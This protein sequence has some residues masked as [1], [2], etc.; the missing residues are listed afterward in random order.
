MPALQIVALS[1]AV[2][3]TV[4]GVSVFV[5][6]ARAIVRTVAVGRSAPDRTTEPWRRTWL[7]VQ[8]LLGHGRF[9]HRPGVKVAHWAVMLSFPIL[10]LTLVSGYGQI[11]DPRFALPLIGHWPPLEWLTE[12]FAWLSLV[13][14]VLLIVVRQRSRPRRG[15]ARASS[16]SAARTAPDGTGNPPE[17]ERASRFFGSNSAQAYFVEAVVL[18]VVLA[19]LLLRGLESVLASS[20]YLTKGDLADG[21]FTEPF[22][23]WGFV[24]PTSAATLAHFPLTAWIGAL[25]DGLSIGVVENAVVLTALAKIVLSMT[26]MY[27]VGR[28]PAMGVSWHRFLAVVN[29]WARRDTN[30]KPALGPLAPVT[31]GGVPVDL[32]EL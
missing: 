13:G 25:L 10:F 17:G 19:V 6:G 20:W 23:T 28:R 14:I 3:A 21:T 29:V 27:V 15:T 30:G 12:I 2:V 26:W 5:L 11:V 18:G 16:V 32:T 1:L 7:V 8:L 4:V 24:D 9:Q 22:S 31:A